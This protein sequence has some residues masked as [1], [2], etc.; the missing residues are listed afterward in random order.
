MGKKRLEVEKRSLTY[1]DVMQLMDYLIVRLTKEELELF[2]IQAWLTWNQR[3][4]VMYG[5][6]LMDLR[7]LNKRAKEYLEEYNTA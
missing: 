4:R 1:I 3:N 6:N 7:S 5:G 2:W